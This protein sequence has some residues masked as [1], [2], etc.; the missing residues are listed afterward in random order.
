[1]LSDH[2]KDLPEDEDQ[3]IEAEE[4]KVGHSDWQRIQTPTGSF[5]MRSAALTRK[6]SGRPSVNICITRTGAT[7]HA[8]GDVPPIDST[9]GQSFEDFMDIVNGYAFEQLTSHK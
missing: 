7:F 2:Y 5:I 9:P 8:E 1:M 6:A 4:K 3:V